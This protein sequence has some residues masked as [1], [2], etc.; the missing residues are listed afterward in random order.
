MAAGDVSIDVDILRLQQKF[1]RLQT[2]WSEQ[3]LLKGIGL[4][5]LQFVIL[6]IKEAGKEEAWQQMS[7]LTIFARPVRS[8]N[9]HFSSNFA[10]E[11][12]QSFTSRVTGNE[13]A[14]GTA[15]R[16]APFHHFGTG[17]RDIV[18]RNRRFLRFNT[19]SGFVFT[20]RVR[21][22]AIPARP[23]LPSRELAKRIGVE[24]IESVAEKINKDLGQ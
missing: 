14:V 5:Q 16:F 21:N 8:S 19:P 13:V 24:F 4:K 6:N 18:P 9:R 12:Q 11:L 17:P 3:A 7:P 20:K 22:H 23:L 1:K 2:L 15:Q 10:R